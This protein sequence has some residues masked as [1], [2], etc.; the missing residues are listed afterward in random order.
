MLI[1]TRRVGEKVF[2][3]DEDPITITVVNI[4]GNQVH[5]GIKA[6]DDV[7]IHREEIYRRIK[8][9]DNENSSAN[10]DKFY[11]DSFREPDLSNGDN[12]DPDSHTI[13]ISEET[14]FGDDT[15]GNR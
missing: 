13:D 14:E 11:P 4:R 7:P 9:H 6:S 2:I 15:Y 3:G 5:L 12:I 10:G 1:L 8:N